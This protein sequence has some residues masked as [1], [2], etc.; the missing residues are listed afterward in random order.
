MA[1]GFRPDSW[2]VNIAKGT[3]QSQGLVQLLRQ[4]TMSVFSSG[5]GFTG[6]L[7]VDCVW[8]RSGCFS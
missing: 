3:V 8:V 5:R 2:Y 4:E 6:P 7:E 1:R